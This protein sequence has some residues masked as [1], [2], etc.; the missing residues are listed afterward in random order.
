MRELTL[1]SVLNRIIERT[2]DNHKQLK[3]GVDQRRNGMQD[4][5]GVEFTHNGD[6]NNP[7]TFYVSVSPDLVYYERFAFKFIIQP[8]ESSVAGVSGGGSM[9]IG[10]TSL[11]TSG[12]SGS[13]IISGTSTLDDGSIGS[14]T[15]N[16]HTHTVSGSIGGLSYGIKQV[17]TTSKNW[18]VRIHGVDISP[19]L[20]EQ[21]DGDWIDGEGIYPNNRLVGEEDFYD[22]LDVACMLQAEGRTADVEKILAPEFKKVEIISDQPFSVTAFLYL[23]FSHCNR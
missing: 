2:V 8:Y 23:K 20:V 19:Y 11:S 5:Y 13:S 22:I 21:H 1:E 18:R 6:A 4:L 10:D 15:P 3:T 12:G 14:I 7:A 16:P 17:S 9:T